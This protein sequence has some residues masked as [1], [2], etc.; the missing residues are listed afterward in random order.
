VDEDDRP[1]P[2]DPARTEG[3]QRLYT[4]LFER[5][6]ALVDDGVDIDDL[7]RALQGS[8]ML[9]ASPQQRSGWDALRIEVDAY[10]RAR[11]DGEAAV[12][13]PEGF[14]PSPDLSKPP[15]DETD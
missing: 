1:K 15:E 7:R 10:L 12:T 8:F 11:R 2:D 4:E 5:L 9:T 14:V 3:M 13:T 6:G